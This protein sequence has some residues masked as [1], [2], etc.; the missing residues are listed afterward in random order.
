MKQAFKRWGI[1]FGFLILV[2]LIVYYFV[3]VHGAYNYYIYGSPESACNIENGV[4]YAFRDDS[5]YAA[6]TVDGEIKAA[7]RN[8]SLWVKAWQTSFQKPSS[9]MAATTVG[10]TMYIYGVT[11][12]ESVQKVKILDSLTECPSSFTGKRLEELDN[13]LCF[14]LVIPLDRLSVNCE[15]VFVNERDE[16]VSELSD[17]SNSEKHRSLV[18]VLE[19]MV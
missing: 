3:T 1:A 14:C 6:F 13:A 15:L 7:K 2:L 17:I 16:I 4:A 10:N 12:R 11:F 19:E 9:V 5:F 8:T 18:P